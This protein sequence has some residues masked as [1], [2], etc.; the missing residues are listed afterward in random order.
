MSLSWLE[1]WVVFSLGVLCGLG[2]ARG[3][4]LLREYR[5]LRR[6]GA[7][8]EAFHYSLLNDPRDR[9]AHA[10]VQACKQRLR[11]QP[12]LH[13]NWL[14]PLLDETPAL[15]RDIAAIY[16]PD[17]EDPVRAPGLSHFI[18]AIHLT[19]A[20]MADFLQTHRLGRLADVSAMTL[21]KS[22]EMGRKIVGHERVKTL[23]KWYRH[24]YPWY[25]KA[26]PVWQAVRYQSPWMW[27]SFTVTNVTIR[28]VQPIVIDIIARRAIELYSGRLAMQATKTLEG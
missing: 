9:A 21:W 4:R 24:A 8:A 12:T 28:T 19:A 26:L 10:R 17:A 6:A 5:K 23:H 7:A 14:N 1:L 16:Y 22:W 11:W 13:P 2:G 3:W 27:M 25:K 18:R 20:D 15:V